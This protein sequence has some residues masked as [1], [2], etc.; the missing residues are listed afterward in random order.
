EARHLHVEEG[1]VRFHRTDETHG[2][3]AFARF[4]D[5]L[6]V[7]LAGEER[8]Q[9]LASQGLVVHDYDSDSRARDA[10]DGDGGVAM[11]SVW[12]GTSIVTIVPPSSP[13]MSNAKS[14]P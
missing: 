7:G 10:H 2:V 5:D 4:A 9:M 3:T 8:D 14:S 6:D 1:G 13:R 12:N 11:R